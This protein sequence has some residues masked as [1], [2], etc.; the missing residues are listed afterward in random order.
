MALMGCKTITAPAIVYGIK[1]D[2][3]TNESPTYEYTVKTSSFIMDGGWYTIK[4]RNKYRVG[5]TIIK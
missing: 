3:Y 1:Y 2:S 5:D 4:T